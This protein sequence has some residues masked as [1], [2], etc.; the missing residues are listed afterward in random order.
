MREK[1]LAIVS[2]LLIVAVLILLATVAD[3]A[4]LRLLDSLREGG[5]LQA[6]LMGH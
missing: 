6:A 1:E 2:I 3:G 4:T 5:I